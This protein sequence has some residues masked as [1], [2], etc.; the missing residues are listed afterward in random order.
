[1]LPTRSSD[2]WTQGLDSPS[3]LFGTGADDFEL[4]E[5]EDE[6]V[7][8]IEMPGFEREDLQVNWDRG[9]LL[10]SAEHV[11][12]SRGR[13][14]TYRRT[15]RMPKEIEPDEIEAQYRNGVLEIRLPIIGMETRGQEIEI[16]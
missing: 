15:F 7:L 2:R 12:E 13:R 8:S 16:K 9:R 3:R 1:M 4:Y 11:D 6:F 10:V 5:E 14:R